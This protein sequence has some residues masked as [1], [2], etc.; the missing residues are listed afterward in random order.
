MEKQQ[1]ALS[2]FSFNY[3]VEQCSTTFSVPNTV[4]W[5]KYSNKISQKL[6][7]T[8]HINVYTEANYTLA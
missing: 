1:P 2:F 5:A 8:Q 4:H 3:T 6:I 7:D